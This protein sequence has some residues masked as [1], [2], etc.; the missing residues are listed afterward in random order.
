MK[1]QQLGEFGV[2]LLRYFCIILENTDSFVRLS[3]GLCGV[4]IDRD[5]NGFTWMTDNQWT[6]YKTRVQHA[7]AQHNVIT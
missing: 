5:R 3:P 7:C 2:S 6:L 4:S 1:L